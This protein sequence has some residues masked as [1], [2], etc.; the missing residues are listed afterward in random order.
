MLITKRKISFQLLL[1]LMFIAVFQLTSCMDPVDKGLPKR[2]DHRSHKEQNE[3]CKQWLNPTQWTKIENKYAQ[4][5]EL[6][7]YENY[8]LLKV[9]SEVDT[10]L[11]VKGHLDQVKR[12]CPKIQWLKPQFK[13]VSVLSSTF[14]EFFNQLNVVPLI[15]SVT[16]GSWVNSGSLRSLIESGSI[17]DLGVYDDMDAESIILGKPDLVINFSGIQDEPLAIQSARKLAVPVLTTTA[18]KENHPL[19]RA[20]WIKVVGWLTQRE[21]RA[22]N[23]FDSLVVRYESVKNKYLQLSQKNKVKVIAADPYDGAWYVPASE[24]YMGQFIQDAGGEYLWDYPGTGSVQVKLEEAIVKGLKADI[25]LNINIWKSK[26]E[27]PAPY[28]KIKAVKDSQL[29]ANTRRVQG[30]GGND[31]YESGVFHAD[32][33]LSDLG[34]IF[35]PEGQV[36]P[37]YYEKLNP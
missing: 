7:T 9:Y 24:S 17:S 37:I 34:S 16:Y 8:E 11:Y 36:S 26:S 2:T 22:Q 31:F 32:K 6:F 13:K 29:W 18:W 23:K 10:L 27:I 25:W 15:H 19:G 33:I 28:N 1:I 30:S 35:Y 4:N 12:G 5:F 20:E 3:A 14:Y 21:Q